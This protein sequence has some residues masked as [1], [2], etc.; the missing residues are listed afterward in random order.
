MYAAA[1]SQMG[2][3]RRDL[4]GS[5]GFEAQTGIEELARER[6]HLA[7]LQADLENTRSMV[8]AAKRLDANGRR[9]AA[10]LSDS[11]QAASER[12]ETVANALDKL[13]EQKSTHELELQHER[14]ILEEQ[15][16]EAEERH[17]EAL[18]MLST[19]WSRLG[20]SLSREAPQLIRASFIFI[21]P[22]EP[23]REFAFTL[24]LAEDGTSSYKVQDC[25]P[26]IPKLDELLAELNKDSQSRA[27]LPRFLCGMRKAFAESVKSTATLQRC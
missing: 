8:E 4:I 16:C 2:R 19:Y 6:R 12:A 20:L 22:E 25:L 14:H 3:W 10:C 15:R 23:A 5:I 18:R 27:A 17:E 26:Q 21:D 7:D 9:M 11:E 1:E 24:G 13:D